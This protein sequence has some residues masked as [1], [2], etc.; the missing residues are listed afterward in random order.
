MWVRGRGCDG[1]WRM[2]YTKQKVITSW[3]FLHVIG[4]WE[5]SHLWVKRFW[6]P[7]VRSE[8]FCLTLQDIIVPPQGLCPLHG[9][10]VL[11]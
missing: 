3:L 10:R 1:E 7:C 4:R 9:A 8:A 11:G 2:F 6:G 5:G